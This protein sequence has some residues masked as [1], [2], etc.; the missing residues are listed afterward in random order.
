M[1]Y[2][3]LANKWRPKTLDEVIGQ[4]ETIYIIKNI[5]KTKKIPKAYLISGTPGIG[6]TSLARIITKCINCK[7]DITTQP[8]NKCICCT[9]INL[10][11]NTDSIEIDAA[12]TTKVEDI[13][14]LINLSHYKSINNRFKTY[15]IDECHM[16]SINS[17]NSLLKILEDTDTSI[18]YILITTHVHKIPT[19]IISRCLHLKLKKISNDKIKNTLSL[20][21]KN[22]NI[23]YDKDGLQ[24]IATF[25]QGSL[26]YA[27][28][29]IEKIN[30]AITSHNV[31]LVLG[32]TNDE[33]IL[34][35]IKNI[36]E[37]NVKDL[38]KNTKKLIDT[39]SNVENILIQ[40]QIMLYKLSLHK[41]KINYDKTTSQ[42]ILFVYLS[43]NLTME[44]L[45]ELYTTISEEKMYLNFAP[46]LNI[47]FEMILLKTLTKINTT[48][49]TTLKR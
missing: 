24:Y 14:D 39:D 8:C 10:G 35:I 27:L 46:N 34:L 4:D 15:I 44:M 18:I 47:G 20:I 32:I 49:D 25:S 2:I 13:K 48:H 1:T 16:L 23:A 28:N 37:N 42:N 33:N 3:T 43:K 9:S 12:S 26:R 7:I 22:E 31:T 5:L 6:K 45:Q 36:Y 40:I 21:L 41:L 17:F 11:K 29:T 30:T 19:T 38:I